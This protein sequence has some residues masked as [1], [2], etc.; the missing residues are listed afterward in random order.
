VAGTERP[1]SAGQPRWSGR[2]VLAIAAT[3]GFFGWAFANWQQTGTDGTGWLPGFGRPMLLDSRFGSPKYATM[4]EME[5]VSANTQP[6][7]GEQ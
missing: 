1:S 4:Y 6:P 3:T 7:P 5:L 2:N